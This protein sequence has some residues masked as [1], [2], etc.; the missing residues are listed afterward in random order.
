MSSCDLFYTSTVRRDAEEVPGSSDSCN[1][2]DVLTVWR[3]HRIAW[4]EVP[5][6]SEVQWLTT[7]GWSDIQ[8]SWP[9]MPQLS[10]DDHVRTEGTG[11]GDP[12]AI[13]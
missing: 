4:V 1:E 11:I 2:V 7:I 13:R 9:A 12:S 10:I 8:V 5:V 6:F 3:P